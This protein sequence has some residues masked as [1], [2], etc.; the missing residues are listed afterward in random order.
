LK[1]NSDGSLTLFIQRDSPG[2]DIEMNWLPAPKEEFFLMMRMYQPAEKMLQGA[3]IMPPL[4]E[5]K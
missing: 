1:S 2:K 3:Y 5:V 4:Q